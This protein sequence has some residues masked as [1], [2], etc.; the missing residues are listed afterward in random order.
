MTRKIVKRYVDLPAGQVHVHEAGG[1]GPAIVFLHQTASS[2][3]SFEGVMRELRLP[4][5]LIAIDTP[6]FGS[7]FH[8]AGWPSMAKYAGWIVATLDR[9]K[10]RQFH[11]FGFHTGG[12]LALEIARRYP[13][14]ARSVMLL[15]PVSMTKQEREE[16]RGAYDK[17]IAPRADGMHLVENWK[18]AHQFNQ[19]ADL[20]VVHDEVTD[21]LRAW[22]GRP[23]AYR[24]V[25]FH[26]SL[27]QVQKLTC[28]LLFMT[29]P[30]DFFYPRFDAVR[31]LRPDAKV[32]IVGG[33]NMPTRSDPKG[34]AAGIAKFIRAL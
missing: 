17:P 3:A 18:Y 22:R 14:R 33:E 34:V 13:R 4:N 1:K 5:R 32:A 7:S 10:A 19:R 31:A 30:D 11:L 15:G 24:A 2:G 21:M 8:P 26:D 27:A 29:S 12:S 20:E 28:P 25:S 23:Q 9:L 6:G 16:F